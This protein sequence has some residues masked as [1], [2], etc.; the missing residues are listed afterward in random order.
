MD[1]AV[2]QLSPNG[3]GSLTPGAL[4]ILL[5]NGDGTF[6]APQTTTLPMAIDLADAD[7]N[8]DHK[9]DVAITDYDQSSDSTRLLILIGNGDG[10]FQAARQSAVFSGGFGYLASGEFNNDAKADLAIGVSAEVHL[11][12]GNGDGSFQI[13]A[14]AAVADGFAAQGVQAGDANG[15]GK[16]GLLADSY[17]FE[18]P[19]PGHNEGPTSRADNISFFS[20]NGNGTLQAERIAASSSWSK[21]S[22]FSPAV[23][24]AILRPVLGDYDG[25][26]K[27]DVAFLRDTFSGLSRTKSLEIRLGKG[28]ATFLSALRFPYANSIGATA[29]LNGDTL[30]D[31]FFLDA[32]AVVVA[33]NTTSAFK[34]NL[35]P[36]ELPPVHPGGSASLTVSI[37]SLNGF[38]DT[39]TLACSSPASVNVNC[40]DVTFFACDRERCDAQRDYDRCFGRPDARAQPH[41]ILL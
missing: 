40:F 41:S 9:A 36:P 30:S 10:T 18:G 19:P 25:D 12:L 7:F 20:G 13:G 3:F 22:V 28:D 1:L 31:L 4:S 23:G 27:L 11:L 14:D 16:P 21:S 8:L 24:D 38:G 34:V 15:E 5:G 39:V 32:N 6:Q 35:S 33:V 17:H 26:G 29:D 2:F 37:E